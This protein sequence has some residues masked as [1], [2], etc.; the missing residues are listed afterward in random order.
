MICRWS[1][2]YITAFRYLGAREGVTKIQSWI[3]CLIRGRMMEQRGHFSA[4]HALTSGVL[5]KRDRV[6]ACI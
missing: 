2:L 5:K 1:V 4:A 3:A 6:A